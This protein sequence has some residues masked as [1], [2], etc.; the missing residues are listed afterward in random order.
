MAQERLGW[1]TQLDGLAISQGSSDL[2]DGGSF[3]A[4]RAFLRGTAQ[5]NAGGGNSI[6]VSLSFGQFD[7]DFD[8]VADQPWT[9]IRDIRLSVP[10]SFAVS[11]RANVFVSP[12]VRWDYQSGA[13]AS[14]G[15]TYGVFAGVA[16]EISETLTIGPAFGAYSQLEESG[17]EFFPALLVNWDI[18]KRLNLS[19][20]TGLGATSGPGL[21]LGYAWSDA[22]TIALTARSE[23]VRFRLDDQGLAPDGVGEDQSVP[24]VIS[25]TYSPNPGVSFNVFAG[26]ELGG[27]LTLDDASGNEV[28][29]QDYD[30][31]PL[32][33]LAARFRF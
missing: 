18:S 12:G 4:T 11:E 10:I 23:S 8:N 17:A 5:Y 21:T 20:G 13:S 2:D 25:Y 22:S 3:S 7:Y 30:T 6:G 14:D 26:A 9:D 31:A 1:G 24:V 15:E 28:L 29:R 27:R 32:L 19:T 16:W 33:G